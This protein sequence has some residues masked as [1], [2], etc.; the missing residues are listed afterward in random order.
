MATESAKSILEVLKAPQVSELARKRRVDCNPPVGH[1][2]CHA[3]VSL[4]HTLHTH[5]RVY[6]SI[7]LP[8]GGGNR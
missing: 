8:G 1:F 4:Y 7:L 5:T 2:R 3:L 6:F